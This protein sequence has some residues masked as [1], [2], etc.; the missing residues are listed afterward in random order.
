MTEADQVELRE[1]ARWWQDLE[2]ASPGLHRGWGHNGG[3]EIDASRIAPITMPLSGPCRALLY[4]NRNDAPILV[5]N[6]RAGTL[7][8]LSYEGDPCPLSELKAR[9]EVALA[10][11][12]GAHVGE[13]TP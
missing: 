7:G 1:I 2:E 9:L 11:S 4:F 5:Y 10:E 12:V 3:V 6:L 13:V 8:P